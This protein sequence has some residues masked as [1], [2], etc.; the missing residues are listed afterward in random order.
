M[1]KK[2]LLFIFLFQ[3]FVF[4]LSNVI[5]PR[6]LDSLYIDK[7]LFGY[8][9]ALWSFGMMISSPFWGNLGTKYGKKKFVLLGICIY[10]ISQTLFFYVTNVPLL[11]LL[12]I[13]SGF[14]VGA[15]VT[16]MLAHLVLNTD[17]Q[18]RPKSLSSRMA[19]L[20]LGNILS[21]EL[22]GYL[23]LTYTSELFLLQGV[24]SIVLFVIVLFGVSESKKKICVYPK[25]LNII[26]SLKHIKMINKNTIFFLVSL[27]LV[28]MTFVNIDK[29]IDLFLFDQ[30]HS[31][32]VVGNVKVL[33][34]LVFITTNIFIVPRLKNYLGSVYVLQT[35]T[36]VMGI[37][38]LF[39]FM[40][41]T[42][43]ILLCTI[44]LIFIVLKGIYT[45]SEQLFLSSIVAN[46]NITVFMGL[47]QSF[48]SLGMVI[49]P[50]IGGHMYQHNQI[51]VF[52]F[53]VMCL[54]ISSLL[55][56]YIQLKTNRENEYSII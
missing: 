14:G 50:I 56:S 28:T 54:L 26:N 4:N 46:E 36:V 1:K 13:I 34:G 43:L 7:Y 38:I 24:L 8:F 47:R 55:L 20:T 37:I 40:Q 2:V 44:F 49:G 27:T 5:T 19:F 51:N 16:L 11:F 45:T 23:G 3:A 12:R 35:I 25:Q 52:L 29:F 22:S 31:V 6:Y 53:S 42:Y 17:V 18:S 39:V 15:I 10:G 30:G 48:T 33:F 41:T 32:S 9:I 21:Y